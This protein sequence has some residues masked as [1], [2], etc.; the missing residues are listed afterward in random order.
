[1]NR[2]T[3]FIRLTPLAIALLPAAVWADA[4][5]DLADLKSRLAQLEQQVKESKNALPAMAA[6]AASGGV[7]MG[8]TKFTFGGYVKLDAIASRFGK[9]EVA[10][11]STARDFY[12]PSATP[13]GSGDPS[14]VL[15]L[16][17]K[18]SRFFFKTETPAGA[19][20]PVRSHIELDFQSPQRGTERVTNNFDPGLRHAYLTYGKWLAGQ[21]WSTFMDLGALPETVEFV[22]ASDGTVFSRQPQLR[23]T[24]GPWQFSLENDQ[25]TT[26]ASGSALTF[27]DTGDNVAPDLVARYTQ[28]NALGYASIAV[29][30]RQLKSTDKAMNLSDTA[31]G[32]GVSLS[33]KLKVGTRGDD[34]R[35]MLTHGTGIGRYVALGLSGDAT[36]VNGKL[37]PITVSAG[38]LTYRHL[39]TDLLRT[40]VQ[41]AGTFVDNP[42]SAGQL[43]NKSS[44]SGLVN[45]IY[46]LT[47]KLE[48]GAEYLHGKREIESGLTGSL[49]RVQFM[50]KHLF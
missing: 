32:M 45:V 22:G 13:V 15:D 38:Y 43:A 24:T 41:V 42:A 39:W 48:V 12:V 50:A 19:E 2:L 23:Y 16:H 49:D 14:T 5:S 28:K 29:L 25:T 44:M 20:G 26:E 21:T 46:N 30:G 35:F 18:Q 8:D 34:I 6:P 31:H 33:G 9:G 36:F 27:T 1:M 11:T 37:D 7:A 3:Q 40:N 4:A 47:P 10:S 17:A